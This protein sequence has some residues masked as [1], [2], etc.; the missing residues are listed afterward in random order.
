VVNTTILIAAGAETLI[1]VSCVEQGRWT[2]KTREFKSE[3]RV[4]SAKIRAGKADQVK[5]SL[6]HSGRFASD[7]GAIWGQI[8]DLAQG[9]D[10][11]SPSTAMADIYRKE[12]PA[13]TEYTREF[14][15]VDQQVGA[16]FV[17]NGRIAGMECFGKPET[18]EKALA[19][20]VESYALDALE[21][22]ETGVAPRTDHRIAIEGFVKEVRGCRVESRPSVGVGMDC[23]LESDGVTGFALAHD[24]QLLHLSVFGRSE[25][26]R[27]QFTGFSL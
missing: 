23:R 17:I 8:Q 14:S 9:F 27:E 1:R 18:L 2:Y 21:A 22:A 3:G 13:L 11:E 4:M 25:Q 15:P 16:V 10:V 5:C 19:K 6:R 20:L 24:G 12:R 26:E 7:Q